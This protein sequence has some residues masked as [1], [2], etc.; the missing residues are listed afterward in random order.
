M[1]LP[2]VCTC[3]SAEFQCLC[4]FLRC[5][6]S[7]LWFFKEATWTL[8]RDSIRCGQWLWRSLEEK[9]KK[10]AITCAKITPLV[11]WKIGPNVDHL[12][13]KAL[14]H[15]HSVRVKPFKEVLLS[16]SLSAAYLKLKQALNTHLC[17]Q[18]TWQVEGDRGVSV[19]GGGVAQEELPASIEPNKE[20][21]SFE[22]VKPKTR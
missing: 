20:R 2:R 18:R 17:P 1:T 11:F 14:V 8:T 4:C 10:K 3:F 19:E 7:M 12:A 5:S 9:K 16:S 15:H 21:D 6:V 22:G 13:R